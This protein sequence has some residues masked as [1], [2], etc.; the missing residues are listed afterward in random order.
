MYKVLF[1]ILNLNFYERKLMCIAYL[2]AFHCSFIN[3]YVRKMLPWTNK[4]H[5]FITFVQKIKKVLRFF[6]VFQIGVV[7]RPFLILL[8]L[9]GTLLNK[10][11]Y[12]ILSLIVRVKI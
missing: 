3:G 11:I 12:K 10:Y 9:K 2:L 5:L 8:Y 6:F 4:C 1:T 7:E